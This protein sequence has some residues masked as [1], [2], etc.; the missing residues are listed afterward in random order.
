MVEF[1]THVIVFIK[2]SRQ[3]LLLIGNLSHG[4]KRLKTAATAQ[5]ERIVVNVLLVWCC[6]KICALLTGQT[7]L[8]CVSQAAFCAAS[9]VVGSYIDCWMMVWRS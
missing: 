4:L 8:S 6:Q 9:L 2:F 3:R 7:I 1:S 5:S